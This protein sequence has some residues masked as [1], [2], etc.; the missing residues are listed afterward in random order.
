VITRGRTVLAEIGTVVALGPSRGTIR[1]A[2]GRPASRTLTDR[3]G[4]PIGRVTL[5]IQDDTGYIKLMQ[6][7][8]GADLLLRTPAGPVPGS[9]LSPGPR[10]LPTQGALTYVGRRYQATALAAHAF[11]SG[12]LAVS[13]LVPL[14]G[15]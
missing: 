3:Q 10:H 15:S 4:R 12:P 13:L 8:T 2:N 14:A 9:T 11:P 5:S 7:F 1:D 6:R